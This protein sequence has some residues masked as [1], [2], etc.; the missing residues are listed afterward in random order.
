LV[1]LFALADELS[2]RPEESCRRSAMGRGYYYIYHLALARSLSNG[3]VVRSGEGTHTQLWR[4]FNQSP[5]PNT[6]KLGQLAQRLKEKRERADY[7]PHY[8]RLEDELPKMIVEV[9][10]FAADLLAL[11]SRFPQPFSR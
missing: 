1:N 4:I 7:H 2:R 11:P 8:P 10:K 6:R 9:R 5:D 3:L